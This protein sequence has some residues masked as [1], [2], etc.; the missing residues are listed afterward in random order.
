MIAV[1]AI[2]VRLVSTHGAGDVF[3]G[4]FAAA[5]AEGVAFSDCLRAA[6]QAAAVHVSS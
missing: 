4:S 2:P 5:L 3:V 6:N 1:P